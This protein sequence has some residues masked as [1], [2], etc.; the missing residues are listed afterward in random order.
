[1][2]G[3]SCK[4]TRAAR[5]YMYQRTLQLPLQTRSMAKLWGP[6]WPVAKTTTGADRDWVLLKQIPIELEGAE[7][8]VEEMGVEELD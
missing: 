3:K 6:L 5:G 4:S 1:M 8:E 2:P 7:K